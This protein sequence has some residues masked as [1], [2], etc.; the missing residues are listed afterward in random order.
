MISRHERWIL[1]ANAF[2]KAKNKRLVS[3]YTANP[4]KCLNC[5]EVILYQKRRNNFCGS[6]CSATCNNKKRADS[7]LYVKGETKKS[8]CFICDKDV[9]VSLHSYEKNARCIDHKLYGKFS[10][11]INCNIEFVGKRLTCSNECK[12]NRLSIGGKNSCKSRSHKKVSNCINCN[13]ETLGRRITCSNECR[14]NRLSIGGRKSA[15]FQSESRRSVNEVYFSELCEKEFKTVYTNRPMFNGWDADIILPDLKIAIMWNGNWHHK[16]ITKMHSLKQV[17]NRDAIKTKEIIE[18][19]YTPYI[20]SDYGKK[21]KTFVEQQF[22]IFLEY[23][24]RGDKPCEAIS[25]HNSG[26]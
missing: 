22:K 12:R 18:C 19:G 25:A 26:N 6:K 20:I 9:E 7:S 11:C 13:A 17:H 10:N 23:I 24:N 16:K 8:K 15:E 21:N 3:D 4:K 5:G 14:R 2:N 1:G